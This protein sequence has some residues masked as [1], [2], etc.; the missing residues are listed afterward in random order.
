MAAATAGDLRLASTTFSPFIQCSTWSPRITSRE[1]LTLPHGFGGVS[2][3]RRLHIVERSS[4]MQ[5]PAARGIRILPVV[6][7][8]VFESHHIILSL[9]RA[10]QARV[11]RRVHGVRKRCAALLLRVQVILNA[12]F[13][14]AVSGRR[15]LPGVRLRQRPPSLPGSAGGCGP[16]RFDHFEHCGHQRRHDNHQDYLVEIA[17]HERHAAQPVA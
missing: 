12:V 10:L 7:Q 16:P 3:R 1:L 13:N 4:L 14:A 8:L 2:R 9:G 17:P 5:R 15:D 6:H 11:E